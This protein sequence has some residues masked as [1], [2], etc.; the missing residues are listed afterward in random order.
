ML[1]IKEKFLIY[2]IIIL[3][4]ASLT[5][6]VFLY[7]YCPP[8]QLKVN[9]L[10]VGQGDS[11]LI[12]TPY[13][14]NIL[15]DGGDG[16]K[17]LQEL[18][19]FMPFYDRTIDLMILTHPHDDHVGGLVKVLQRYKVKKIL[20][21]GVVHTSPM[22]LEWLAAVRRKNIPLVIIDRPQTIA[23]G[24]DL[25]L[26]ILYPLE[27]LLNKE[28]ENL[29]NSSIVTKLIYKENK[30]LFMGDAEGEIENDLAPSPFQDP[31]TSASLQHLPL[32]RGGLDLSADVLKAGHHG[33]DTSNSEK[34]LEAVKPKYAIIQVGADNDFGHPSLRVLKRF[35][36]VG[37][38]IF[39]N[40]L[41]GWVQV[42]SDGYNIKINKE[43]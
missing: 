18:P 6:V 41:N 32:V 8:E 26:E 15:I 30:F 31:S 23:L 12:K 20:Y 34:F 10:D 14:Q 37:V 42:I 5:L 4:I 11:I 3:V 33:S 16:K 2:S 38:E 22:Y 17:I 24:A 19:K 7:A 28:V 43:K 40:D 27:S 35:E 29:N 9:F 13:G 21:T 25:R 36:R 39:R 1:K